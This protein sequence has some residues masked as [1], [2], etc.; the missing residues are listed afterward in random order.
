M[1]IAIITGASAGLGIEFLNQ[2]YT[3]YSELDCIWIIARRAD[4]LNSLAQSFPEGK[5]LPIALDLTKDESIHALKHMLCESKA[6]VR[7]LI[8]NAGFGKLGNVDELDCIEQ[9]DIVA[10]N[11][12]ALTAVTALVLNHMESGSTVIN[13]CSISAFAPNPRMTVYSATKAYVMSFSRSLRFELKKK[14]INVLAVCPGPMSTEF[15]GIAG[16]GKGDSPTYDT[17]PFCIPTKVVRGALNACDK[18]RGVYTPTLFY[19]L[20]RV[21]A[22]LLP[23]S[24]VMYFS[25]T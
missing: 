15:L 9:A 1:N 5:V 12:R 19:K 7:L 10:L 8:N 17:L 13:V 3:R 2:V 18:R 23:H 20:Y 24:L 21:F 14:N 4:R 6:A 25:K 22:K 11:C 16:I